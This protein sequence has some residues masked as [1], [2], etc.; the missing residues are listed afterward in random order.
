[1]RNAHGLAVGIYFYFLA[2]LYGR[3]QFMPQG[4]IIGGTLA[5]DSC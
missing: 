5:K 1:M 3:G 4:K 2:P